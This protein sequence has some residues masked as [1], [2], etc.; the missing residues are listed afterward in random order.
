[1]DPAEY[2]AEIEAAEQSFAQAFS[3]FTHAATQWH[4]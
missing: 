4:N 1:V 2:N 3:R